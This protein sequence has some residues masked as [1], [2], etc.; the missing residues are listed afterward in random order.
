MADEGLRVLF[1]GLRRCFFT[2]YLSLITFLVTTTELQPNSTEL[3]PNYNPAAFFEA[4]ALSVFSQREFDIIDQSDPYAACCNKSGDAGRITDDQGATRISLERE[5]RDL[6]VRDF[7][8]PERVHID[9]GCISHTNG[10]SRLYFY[11]V[12]WADSCNCLAT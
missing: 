12:G 5:S 9:G 11:T 3:Q 2:Y 1:E 8:G 4:A 7:R 6:V 10:I